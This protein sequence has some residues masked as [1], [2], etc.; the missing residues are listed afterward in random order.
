LH[1]EIALKWIGCLFLVSGWLLALTALALL[2]GLGQRLAFVLAGIG[3]EALGLVLVARAAQPNP[4]TEAGS[5][6]AR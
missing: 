1:W 2:P 6:H 5:G 4:S 3:M